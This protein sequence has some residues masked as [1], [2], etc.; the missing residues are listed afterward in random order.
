MTNDVMPHF[1]RGA[2]MRSSRS[3]SRPRRAAVGALALALVATLAW[4]GAAAADASSSDATITGSFSDGCR[5]FVST[6]TKLGSGQGKDISH[7]EIHYA[8]GRTVKDETVDSPD[9]SLDGAAGDELESA[10]VKSGT[11]VQTFACPRTNSPPT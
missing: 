8:D 3:G 4:A 6:A 7:V 10:S 9:Y 5:D 2:V 11:T 1:A